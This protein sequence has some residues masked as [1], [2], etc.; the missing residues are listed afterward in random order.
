MTPPTTNPRLVQLGNRLRTLFDGALETKASASTNPPKLRELTH[1][2]PPIHGSVVV[3]PR[4]QACRL[5]CL[6]LLLLG[7]PL[8]AQYF[9]EAPRVNQSFAAPSNGGFDLDLN[10]SGFPDVLSF[11]SGGPINVWLDPGVSGFGPP[12]PL[13]LSGLSPNLSTSYSWGAFVPTT[14]DAQVDFIGIDNAVGRVRVLV[15]IPTPPFF[16]PQTATIGGPD[17][18]HCAYADVNGDG[19]IDLI[20]SQSGPS[21]TAPYEI[22]VH[23]NNHPQWPVQS[24]FSTPRRPLFAAPGDFDGDSHQDLAVVL[25]GVFGVPSV[26]AFDDVLLY[27]GDGTGGFSSPMFQ[28]AA[29]LAP[30]TQSPPGFLVKD[31]DRDGC[32]DLYAFRIGGFGSQAPTVLRV[33]WGSPSRLLTPGTDTTLPG[34]TGAQSPE[35]FDID[36]DGWEDLCCKE[37][38]SPSVHFYRCGH[39]LRNRNFGSQLQTLPVIISGFSGI[40]WFPLMIRA[41][42]DMDGDTDLIT[43]SRTQI[44]LYHNEAVYARGCAGT[45]GKVPRSTPATAFLGSQGSAFYVEDALPQA[46]ALFGIS[47]ARNPLGVFPCGIGIDFF[48]PASFIPRMTDATGFAAVPI[49]IPGWSGL[50]GAQFSIQWA[51]ADPAGGFAGSTT[52]IAL[53]EA[54]TVYVW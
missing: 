44:H 14:R 41:D 31:I 24:Q 40:S 17:T 43:H 19:W 2:P 52:N 5:R 47:V 48:G 54:R 27:F 7:S 39:N 18:F 46:P 4:W 34:A 32:S 51:V 16:I 20:R 38:N 26:P 8:L 1:G 25:D 22:V 11:E 37:I 42:L 35:L 45:G 13:V 6:T 15:G 33:L 49:T 30:P 10:A 3:R 21:G 23:A 29:Y 9:V 28:S 53:S 50:Q 12:Y 36:G